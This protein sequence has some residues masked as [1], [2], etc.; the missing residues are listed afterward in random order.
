MPSRLKSAVPTMRHA[1]RCARADHLANDVT[2]PTTRPFFIIQICIVASDAFAHR[3]SAVPSRLKSPVPTTR[4]GA[5]CAQAHRS[6]QRRADVR[7]TTSIQDRIFIDPS[8]ASARRMS[9]LGGIPGSDTRYPPDCH[10]SRPVRVE[11]DR[12]PLA[13]RTSIRVGDP[14]RGPTVPA[15]RPTPGAL[16]RWARPPHPGEIGAGRVQALVPA[17]CVPVFHVDPSDAQLH[18]PAEEGQ[19]GRTLPDEAAASRTDRLRPARKRPVT[20][21]VASASRT[22]GAGLRAR[23]SAPSAAPA[24]AVSRRR[25]H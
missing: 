12:R 2:L 10:G 17:S 22:T 3:M 14:V 7:D 6:P 8:D 25:D 15:R 21:C 1:L 20:T 24:T 18:H 11:R 23:C 13:S 9:A 5:R 4:H 16:S 19:K